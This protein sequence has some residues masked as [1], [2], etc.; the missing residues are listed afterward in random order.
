MLKT[1]IVCNKQHNSSVYDSKIFTIAGENTSTT[2]LISTYIYFCLNL[3]NIQQ[4]PHILNLSRY[5][6]TLNSPK[7]GQNQ[8][9]FI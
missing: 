7:R 6:V 1:T 2:S 9:K 3:M 4:I 5:I 8:F